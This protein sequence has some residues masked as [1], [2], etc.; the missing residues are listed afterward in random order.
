MRRGLAH[1]RPRLLHL[2]LG[3]SSLPHGTASPGPH[4]LS[5][6]GQTVLPVRPSL[7]PLL[8]PGGGV[9]LRRGPQP[10]M[11]TRTVS[12]Y[13][14]DTRTGYRVISLKG[15]K[16]KKQHLACGDY[17]LDDKSQGE[18]SHTFRRSS[19]T[20]V[21]IFNG[22]TT[23]TPHRLECYCYMRNVYDKVAA[24]KTA[25]ENRGGEQ[26]DGH[27]IPL[28]ANVSYKPISSKDGQKGQW[29]EKKQRLKSKV[30]RRNTEYVGLVVKQDTLQRGVSKGRQ[31]RHLD[32]DEELQPWRL[33]E[34]SENEQ[35]QR[36]ISRRD[37]Q[38][39]KKANQASL[40]SVE[41]RQSPRL[42]NI[43]E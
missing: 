43:L 42:K 30:A 36:V 12:S 37:K 39:A 3:P 9:P 24:V 8:R 15:K 5:P 26:C 21:G 17:C 14:T 40:L 4:L 28:G 18:T 25:C 10:P 38:K 22:H 19:A 32:N 6:K 23:N 31:Q 27:L 7:G 33:L 2:R 11:I 35:W 1:R 34:E 41:N 16:H 29:Q 20:R 13:K